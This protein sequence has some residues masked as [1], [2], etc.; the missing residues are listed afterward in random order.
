MV[1]YSRL[2]SQ[3]GDIKPNYVTKLKISEIGS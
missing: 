2:R 1:D 3:L